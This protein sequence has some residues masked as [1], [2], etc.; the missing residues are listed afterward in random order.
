MTPA[1]DLQDAEAGLSLI[2]LIM[3]VLIASVV[4]G[5]VTMILI[6]SWR[7]QE[8][9]LSQTEA[10][11]QGQLVSSA[12]ERAVRNGLAVEVSGGDTLRVHT[13]LSGERECQGMSLSGGAA[14]LTM[15]SGA[16]GTGWPVWQSGIV[17]IPGEPLLE[18][19]GSNVSYA[20]QIDTSTAPV[21]FIGTVTARNGT[22]G[23]SSP[24]W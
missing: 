12:I 16:L 23:A 13:T 21:R 6:N 9:V 10:T 18:A 11:N 15:T 19:D 22:G 4:L 17:A 20:F 3:Y 7:T 8:D 1:T 5:A 24:C 2:E 14:S